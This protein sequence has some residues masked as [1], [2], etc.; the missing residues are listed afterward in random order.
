MNG[1]SIYTC[2]PNKKACKQSC[3]LLVL[4]G[5][6]ERVRTDDPHNAIVV[7]YQ[8]SYDPNQNQIK[9]SGDVP[10]KSKPFSPAKRF[11]CAVNCAV[12]VMT[13]TTIHICVIKLFCSVSSFGGLLL[14]IEHDE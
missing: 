1:S 10:S 14:V 11:S 6:A 9:L 3:R 2:S 5:G 12:G 7:L 8:L 13:W 4:D